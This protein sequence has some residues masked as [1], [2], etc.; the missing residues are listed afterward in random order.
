M[1]LENDEAINK[2]SGNNLSDSQVQ[3]VANKIN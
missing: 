3:F 2:K 1:N